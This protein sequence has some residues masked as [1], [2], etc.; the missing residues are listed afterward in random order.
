MKC[1][2]KYVKNAECYSKII[3]YFWKFV[4][5]SIS[6]SNNFKVLSCDEVISSNDQK[7]FDLFFSYFSSVYFFFK[8]NLIKN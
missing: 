5:Y 6:S 1:F 8:L 3:Q 7:A 2:H 4:K